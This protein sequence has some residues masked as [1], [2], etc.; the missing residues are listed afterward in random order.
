MNH[1]FLAYIDPGSGALLLQ[2]IVVGAV[3]AFMVFRNAVSVITSKLFGRRRSIE[4]PSPDL[5]QPGQ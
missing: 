5:S 3:G 2:A 1:F 4:P